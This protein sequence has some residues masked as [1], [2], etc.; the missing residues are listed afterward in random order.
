TQI[1]FGATLLPVEAGFGFKSAGKEQNQNYSIHI[2]A[3]DKNRL[4]IGIVAIIMPEL[5][6]KNEF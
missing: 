5:W 3:N 1:I 6:I 2:K 4:Q